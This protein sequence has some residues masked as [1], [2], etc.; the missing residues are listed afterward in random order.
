MIYS[1][2]ADVVVALHLAYV[3]YVIFGE[4]LIIVGIPLRWQ[5][6]RNFWFRVTHL[7]A[8]LYPAYQM[9]AGMDCPLT[10]WEVALLNAAG[11]PAEQRSFVG[12]LLND[13]MFFDCGDDSWVWPWI[14]GSLAVI[15]VLTFVLAPPRWRKRRDQLAPSCPAGINPA[16]R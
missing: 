16:A 9:F 2:L 8:M 13:L 11:K 7:V 3:S 12:R 1:I 10:V 5:W 15:F 6:I 4:L 14:Y